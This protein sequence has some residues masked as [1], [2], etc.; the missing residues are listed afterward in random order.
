[1]S[2]RYHVL[3]RTPGHDRHLSRDQA[4]ESGTAPKDTHITDRA[5]DPGAL[6]LRERPTMVSSIFE[7]RRGSTSARR[8]RLARQPDP[9]ERKGKAKGRRWHRP[10][11]L[12]NGRWH[13]VARGNSLPH[14]AGLRSHTWPGRRRAPRRFPISWPRPAQKLVVLPILCCSTSFRRIARR[15]MPSPAALFRAS[16]VDGGSPIS[17]M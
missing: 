9:A 17:P 4:A 15:A 13:P 7:L 12:V 10:R 1:M 14:R 5:A 6:R 2:C 3:N 8:A 16:R 11:R